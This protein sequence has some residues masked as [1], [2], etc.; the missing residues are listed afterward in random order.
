M[1]LRL[2]KQVGP[3]AIAHSGPPSLRDAREVYGAN[4]AAPM[5]WPGKG[6]NPAISGAYARFVV[7]EN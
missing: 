7:N 1:Q 3:E 5:W 4:D 2:R 6:G